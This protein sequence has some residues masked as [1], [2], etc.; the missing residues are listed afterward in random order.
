MGVAAHSPL[1]KS[2]FPQ[3]EKKN[4]RG[5]GK[6][7]RHFFFFSVFVII[8]SSDGIRSRRKGRGDSGLG[9]GK[10]PR[11]ALHLPLFWQGNQGEMGNQGNLRGEKCKTKPEKWDRRTRK[12]KK[13]IPKGRKVSDAESQLGRWAEGLTCAR[14]PTCHQSAR[15]RTWLCL[16][17]S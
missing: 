12:Q 11:W 5:L 9:E 3:G 1:A 6:M 8:K 17:L 2:K 10:C 4:H 16:L 15:V 13:R 7:S 14:L